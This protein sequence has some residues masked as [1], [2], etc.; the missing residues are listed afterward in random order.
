MTHP[1]DQSFMIQLPVVLPVRLMNPHANLTKVIYVIS[2][3]AACVV[4]AVNMLF[5]LG[6]LKA[7]KIFTPG[8]KWSPLS[9]VV[10]TH[11][12]S[13]SFR[14]ATIPIF[15]FFPLNPWCRRRRAYTFG[16]RLSQNTTA[17]RVVPRCQCGR[18]AKKGNFR[19]HLG[20][21]RF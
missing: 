3:A 17:F 14:Y 4:N 1:P 19:S 8:A 11:E 20:V 7:Q 16:L 12:V 5:T 2:L 9:F 13:T 6:A 21:V 18:L 10:L 15:S